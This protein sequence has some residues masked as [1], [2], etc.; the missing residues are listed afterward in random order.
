M[1]FGEFTK[2]RKAWVILGLCTVQCK[3]PISTDSKILVKPDFQ[4]LSLVIRTIQTHGGGVQRN[5]GSFWL[6]KDVM[7][8]WV[9]NCFSHVWPFVTL[10]T[11]AHQAPLS[12]GFSRQE[13]WSGLP[14]PPPGELLDPGIKPEWP[15]LQA[16]SL[17]SE[18]P[19]KLRRPYMAHCYG[20][21]GS[22]PVRWFF[23]VE[24]RH[25]G[26]EKTKTFM[27]HCQ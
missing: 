7:L 15:A 10:W 20:S 22:C 16:D 13:D 6:A 5:E 12:V 26:F 21:V 8:V 4:V 3:Y 23:G 27:N 17:P 2:R 9:P 24:S 19:G 18:P 1:H 14:F 25:C 11:V